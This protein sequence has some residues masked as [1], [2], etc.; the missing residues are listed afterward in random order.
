MNYKGILIDLDNT[1]YNYDTAHEE[2]LNASLE[3]FSSETGLTLNDANRIFN[4]AKKSTHIQLLGTASSHSRILYF[5]RMLEEIGAFDFETALKL[6]AN[7]WHVF[8]NQIKPEPFA[9]EFLKE[10]SLPKCVITD[11]TAMAQYQ[12]LLKLDMAQ[13]IEYLVT[14]EEAGVEKPHPFI[15]NLGLQKLGLKANEVIM[16]GDS[17]EKDC[18][19]ASACGIDSI[20]YKGNRELEDLSKGIHPLNGFFDILHWLE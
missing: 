20:L 18:L 17:Y 7:Y 12:K 5:Q 4:A 9:L 16:I 15:F 11:F 3:L 1:L 19:G 10:I 14:S 6:E 13:W 2:A 8:Y